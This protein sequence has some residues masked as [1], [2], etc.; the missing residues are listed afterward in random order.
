M[1]KAPVSDRISC[2]HITTVVHED[3]DTNNDV[4]GPRLYSLILVGSVMTTDAADDTTLMVVCCREKSRRSRMTEP[5]AAYTAPDNYRSK[6]KSQHAVR[7][8]IGS[9]T[10]REHVRMVGEMVAAVLMHQRMTS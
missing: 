5:Q 7:G 1:V 3:G 9:Q 4:I 10:N 8:E 2:I 6:S